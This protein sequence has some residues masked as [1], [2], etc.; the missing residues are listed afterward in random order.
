MYP[1]IYKVYF[2]DPDHSETLE[3]G[4]GFADSFVEATDK[5]ESLYGDDLIEIVNLML[6]EE[7][8]LYI[9]QDV[10]SYDKIRNN[11]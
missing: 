5:I 2:I 8:P 10:K 3:G 4:L 1:F 11:Q 6:L 9:F 7:S